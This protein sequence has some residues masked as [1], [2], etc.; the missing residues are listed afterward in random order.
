MLCEINPLIVTPEG[1]IRA[2]DSKFTVDD[3]A[4]Y[5]H[6]DIAEMRDLEAYPPEERAAREKGVTYVKLDGEVGILGNG[7]GL[8][9]ST[10]T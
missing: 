9:M 1:E 4:L 5:K 3:N 10:S 7:A 2:L 6:P 8:V